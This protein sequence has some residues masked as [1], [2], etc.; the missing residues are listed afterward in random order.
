MINHLFAQTKNINQKLGVWI[1]FCVELVEQ[2][3]E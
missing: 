3:K 2:K 1:V